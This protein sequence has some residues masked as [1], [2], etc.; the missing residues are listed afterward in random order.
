MNKFLTLTDTQRRTVF[1]QTATRIKLPIASILF[2]IAYV[3]IGSK[4]GTNQTLVLLGG[5]CGDF[6]GLI[7]ENL[8]YSMPLMMS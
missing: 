2:S 3:N 1:E 6:S 7:V 5:P 4:Y 8:D